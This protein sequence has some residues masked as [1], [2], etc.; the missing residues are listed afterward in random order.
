MRNQRTQKGFTI[1]E[2]MIIVGIVGIL[3]SLAIPAYSLY[4][5]RARFSEALLAIGDYRSSILVAAQK[6]RFSSVNDVDAGTNGISPAQVQ[7]ATTHGIDV[8][9]GTITVTWR[10]DGT[11]LAGETYSLTAQGVVPPI[12]WVK[13]G[14]CVASG[15]C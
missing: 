14:S 12:Q 5:N 10:T 1:I 15:Y 13:G 9:D 4:Q 3:A 2:L 7:A 6:E 11:A 8:V